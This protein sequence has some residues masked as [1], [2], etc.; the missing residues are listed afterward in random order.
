MERMLSERLYRNSKRL[1][2]IRSLVAAILVQADPRWLELDDDDM[3]PAYGVRRSLASSRVRAGPPCPS[4]AVRMNFQ[5]SA[6]SPTSPMPGRQ[7]PYS[8]ARI[9]LDSHDH[10]D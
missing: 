10:H 8:R 4:L 6:P 7:P 5:I 3:L 9:L 2:A 1:A